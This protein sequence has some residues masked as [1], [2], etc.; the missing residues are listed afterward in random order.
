MLLAAASGADAEASVAGAMD[1]CCG[2]LSWPVI[3]RLCSVSTACRINRCVCPLRNCCASMNSRGLTM[4]KF[5]EP[6]G[7]VTCDCGSAA[8]MRM[9]T[10]DPFPCSCW[11][12]NDLRLCFSNRLPGAGSCLDVM[13]DGA[14]D[15]RDEAPFWPACTLEAV[16]FLR[17][18][19]RA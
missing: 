14:E 1:A 15:E 12:T 16:S 13:S 7:A 4:V 6:Y 2:C 17:Y 11:S 19:S 5:E 18:V 9:P 3:S 10:T 8:L